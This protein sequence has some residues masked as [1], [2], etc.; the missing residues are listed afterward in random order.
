[1]ITPILRILK[2]QRHDGRTFSITFITIA[3]AMVIISV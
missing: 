2:R 1:M 3:T